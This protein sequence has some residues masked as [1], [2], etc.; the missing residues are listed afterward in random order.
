MKCDFQPFFQV[1]LLL[2]ILGNL[3]SSLSVLDD[4]SLDYSKLQYYG[5][6]PYIRHVYHVAI[7]IC[8]TNKQHM[9]Y[10]WCESCRTS[11][12]YEDTPPAFNYKSAVLRPALNRGPAF[13]RENTVNRIWCLHSS[14]ELGMFLRSIATFSSSSGDMTI[15]KSPS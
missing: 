5:T 6:V 3:K 12:W 14:L 4:F 1:D 10:I 11:K 15:N 13:N 2:P 9:N 8:I 7:K